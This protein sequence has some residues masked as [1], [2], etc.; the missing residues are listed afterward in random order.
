MKKVRAPLVIVAIFFVISA[1][2]QDGKATLEAAARA[3][4]ATNLTSIQYSGSG[5]T[6]PFAQA[7]TPGG[8]WPRQIAKTYSVAINYQTP[9]MR[10]EVVRAQGRRRPA[11]RR[12]TAPSSGGER[13]GTPGPKAPRRQ[14]L[15][16]AP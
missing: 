6:F 12:G 1:A 11:H 5:F 16:P 2:A 10:Q 13:F 15:N 9:A 7:A 8:P 4:G 14:T 3:M